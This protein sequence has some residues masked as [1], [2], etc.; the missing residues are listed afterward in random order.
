MSGLVDYIDLSW[1]QIEASILLMYEKLVQLGFVYYNGKV[2]IIEPG[3]EQNN[4]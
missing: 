1:K 4:D 2:V 3:Q